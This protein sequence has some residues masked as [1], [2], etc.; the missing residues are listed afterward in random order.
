MSDKVDAAIASTPPTVE[1]AQVQIQ[2][3]P[4]GRPAIVAMPRDVTTE[5]ALA[6]LMAIPEIIA[7]LRKANPAARL[8]ATNGAALS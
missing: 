7:E 6:L 1:M 3:P 5:E 2:L 8:V 4:R